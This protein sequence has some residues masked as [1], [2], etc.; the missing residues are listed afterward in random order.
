MEEM[1]FEPE[2]LVASS[3]RVEEIDAAF[4]KAR[5]TPS[6]INEHI[7]TLRDLA[8]ECG[9]V[10]E[11]GTRTGVSTIAFL[12]GLTESES[13]TKS[14]VCCDLDYDDALDAIG[15]MAVGANVVF[16]F[17][18]VNDLKLELGKHTL[19][20]GPAD[21][22]FIDT[23]HVYGHLKRELKKFS[24]L[25]RKYIA[26]HDTE[27]DAIDG[28]SVRC[29]WNTLEQSRKYGYP[30]SEIRR[31]IWPAVEEFL[32]ENEGTWKLKK[33]YENNNGLSILERII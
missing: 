13:T 14:L 25:A 3:S 26:L 22:V 6:D 29:D 8:R 9:S 24:P 19:F 1:S 15:T 28:E 33:H 12:K 10:L 2:P 16:E 21:L 20:S 5:K 11:L 17:A 7:E 18:R 31:G 27:V 23:W 4:E 30:E 32:L